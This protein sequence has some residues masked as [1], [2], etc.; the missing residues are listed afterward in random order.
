MLE[1]SSPKALAVNTDGEGRLTF[2]A[3]TQVDAAASNA[4]YSAT[5]TFP[6]GPDLDALDDPG[7]GIKA[8]LA[9]A[10]TNGVLVFCGR[11]KDPEGST[12]IWV[13]LS[14]ATPVV[15]ASTAVQ[16]SLKTEG[17]VLKAQYAVNGTVLTYENSE[18]LALAS[19][20]KILNGSKFAGTASTFPPS[21]QQRTTAL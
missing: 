8:G 14:G 12:N 17:E 15:D 11:A 2:T 18:W 1:A 19:A 5:M 13:A 4:V 6:S 9:V 16:V 7:E 3:E 10:T 20:D 21:P